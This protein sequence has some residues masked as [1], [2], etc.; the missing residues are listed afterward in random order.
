MAKINIRVESKQELQTLRNKS[1]S[2]RIQLPQ[3]QAIT[4]RKLAN[5]L[6]LEAIQKKMYERGFSQKIID[7]TEITN[8]EV[9]GQKKVR[10]FVKSEYFSETGFD[11]ALAREKGTKRHFIEPVEKQAL[12]FIELGKVKFSKGHY[13]DGMIAFKTVATSIAES[14]GRFQDEYN[15][16]LFAWLKNNLGDVV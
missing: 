9:K 10:I 3:W 7:G 15:R 5:T 6:I 12:R 16:Q 4:V 2:V 11:V 1:R 8:I 14:K 13:V